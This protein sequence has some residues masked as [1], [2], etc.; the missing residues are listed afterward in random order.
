MAVV[1]VG[2]LLV[3]TSRDQRQDRL[4]PGKAD[5]PRVGDHWHA[6]YGIFVCGSF[7]PAISDDRDPTGIHTHKTENGAGD[8]IVHVHPFTNAAAG[9]NATLGKF[10]DT[11]ELTLKKGELKVPGG[12]TFKDGDDCSG[13]PAFLQLKVNGKAYTGDP[14]KLRL[15]DRQFITIAFVP[16]GT[17]IPDPPS[18]DGLDNLSDVPPSEQGNPIPITPEA[19]DPNAPVVP[20]DP[21]APAPDET[22][23]TETQPSE[24]Q[25]GESAPPTTSAAP[26]STAP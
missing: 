7:L 8:G 4:D 15:K 10:A 13:K 14:G 20:N 19:N 6:A 12:K 5:P 3:V 22:A 11:V 16:K 21:N 26:S 25:P 1:L 17:T 23:P 18:K 2:V 24:T 9:K